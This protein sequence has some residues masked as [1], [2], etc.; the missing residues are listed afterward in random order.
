M[1]LYLEAPLCE[2]LLFSIVDAHFSNAPASSVR[3]ALSLPVEALQQRSAHRRKGTVRARPAAKQRKR[4]ARAPAPR[5]RD[6]AAKAATQAHS[7]TTPMR[8]R[9]QGSDTRAQLHHDH[10]TQQPRPRHTRRTHL[11]RADE[12]KKRRPRRTRQHH[13]YVSQQ[14]YSTYKRLRVAAA[15]QYVQAPT[16]ITRTR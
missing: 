12:T 10:A 14:L 4:C 6:E 5:P 1:H 9:I 3:S 16:C 15:V 2:H 8:R 13:A 7:C 11:L